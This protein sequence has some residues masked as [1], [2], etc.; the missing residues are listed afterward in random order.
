MS[1]KENITSPVGRIVNGSLYDPETTD[2]DG[3]PLII[4]TGPNAGL[5]R[6]D[7]RFALA[8][9]K[10]AERHWAET[11][12]GQKI[13][14]IGHAAYPQQAGLPGFAWKV[15]DGD[16]TTPSMKSKPPGKRPCDNEGYK[17]NWI[18]RF[19]GGFAPKIY[20]QEGSG[21][22]QVM[23]PDFVKAGYFVEV[24]FTVE[25]NSGQS[26]GVYINHSMICF[27][28]FGPEITFGPDVGSAGF[29]AAP[30]PPGASATPLASTAPMPQA[31]QAPAAALAPAY[32]P[33]PPVPVTPNTGFVQMPPPAAAPPPP[34]IPAINAK[35]MTALAGA[36]TYAAYIAAGWTD[37]Q[38][39]QNGLMLA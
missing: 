34:S 31:P 13:W 6:K 30:L 12:W 2:F 7:F 37:A 38:L 28:A 16:D 9:P 1:Q 24:F 26:P 32:S 21:L 14:A 22:V 8:I 25:G 4:K 17:G 3:K 20:Q 19:S 39:V 15:I 27:R 36:T 10:G 18:I 23:Q 35:Q 11:S 5:A 33:P 29:G